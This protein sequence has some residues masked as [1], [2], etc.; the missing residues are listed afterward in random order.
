[1]KSEKEMTFEE[2]KRTW[3]DIS[4][5]NEAQFDALWK[6]QRERQ[7]LVPQPGDVAPDFEIDV[8][9]KKRSRTGE[10]IHLAS[11]RGKPV[12]LLFGSYT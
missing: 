9:D 8:R 4:V 5:I 2:R 7:S 1:M 10:T 6:F 3:L 12:A 11:L